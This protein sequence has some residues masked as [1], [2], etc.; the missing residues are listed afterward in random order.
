MGRRGSQEEKIAKRIDIKRRNR[1]TY[2]ER[3]LLKEIK[4]NARGGKEIKK[5][6]TN[7][8]KVM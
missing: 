3:Y 6:R 7:K 8:R 1:L 2:R 5:R 4:K